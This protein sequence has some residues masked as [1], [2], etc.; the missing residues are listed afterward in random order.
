MFKKIKNKIIRLLGGYTEPE[1]EIVFRKIR[2]DVTRCCAVVCENSY[3][4]RNGED[5]SKLLTEGVLK[6]AEKHIVFGTEFDHY[7]NRRIFTARLDIA[8]KEIESK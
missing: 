6:Q 1:K 3:E 8:T 5:V 7:T 4:C 2:Y